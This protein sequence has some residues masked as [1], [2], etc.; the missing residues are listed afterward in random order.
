MIQGNHVILNKENL[1]PEISLLSVIL[2]AHSRKKCDVLLAAF[3]TWGLYIYV[4]ALFHFVLFILRSGLWCRYSSGWPG[5]DYVAKA[6]L[7]LQTVP[8]PHPSVRIKKPPQSAY[9]SFF[10][11]PKSTS[12]YNFLIWALIKFSFF[13]IFPECKPF[14]DYGLVIAKAS[15]YQLLLCAGTEESWGQ[16]RYRHA[17]RGQS[18]IE[19]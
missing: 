15:R 11:D 5:A 6:G 18:T 17:C 13:L 16:I 14:L 19:K 3:N 10:S 4:G 9:N 12:I 7:K 1:L 8:L 2:N